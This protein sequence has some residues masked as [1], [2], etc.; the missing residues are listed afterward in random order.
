MVES[1]VVQNIL[2]YFGLPELDLV[3]GVS[4]R[5]ERVIVSWNPSWIHQNIEEDLFR[6]I[7]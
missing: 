3:V 7:P 4:G 2:S 1:E 5:G 6:S